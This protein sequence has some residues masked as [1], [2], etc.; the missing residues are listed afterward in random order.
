MVQTPQMVEDTVTRLNETA[1]SWLCL[2]RVSHTHERNAENRRW[3]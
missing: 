2:R 3:A 1:A